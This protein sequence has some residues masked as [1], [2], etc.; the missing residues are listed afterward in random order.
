MSVPKI[1]I[2]RYK[3]WKK[4]IYS[5]NSVKFKKV[6]KIVQK[7]KVLIISCC[8]SRVQ[9]SMIFGADIGDYFIHKNIANL[10]PKYNFKNDV[11]TKAILEY[12]IKT[13]NIPN[14]LIL[15]HSNCGGIDYSYNK[16]I[17]SI[18]DKKNNSLN[19]WVK[20]LE[21]FYKKLPTKIINFKDN[22]EIEKESIKNSIDNLKSY[23]YI[24]N[25]IIKKKLRVY[26]AWYNIASG[27]LLYFNDKTKKFKKIN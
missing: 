4:N 6:S 11:S 27:E 5:K 2:D 1:L 25:L 7:P 24:K 10:I 9:E 3:K 23:P 16:Y 13:L 12:A 14:I 17:N 22:S 8:D 15:G 26:G 18:F 20:I 21:N 19:H